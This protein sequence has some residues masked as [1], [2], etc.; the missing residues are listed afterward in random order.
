MVFIDTHYDN[1]KD[2]LATKKF[3]EYTDTF[4]DFANNVEP[5]VV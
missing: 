2:D 4:W 5:M 3:K 1:V